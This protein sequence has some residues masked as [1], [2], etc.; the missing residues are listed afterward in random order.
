MA[1]CFRPFYEAVALHLKHRAKEENGKWN[2]NGK[3]LQ[4]RP[5]EEST[6]NI[7]MTTTTILSALDRYER[8]IKK[9]T[10]SPTRTP[11]TP[12]I[13]RDDYE[14]NVNHARVERWLLEP[15]LADLDL[16][17]K[18][19]FINT[20][21][22]STTKEEDDDDDDDDEKT[23]VER[24]M[25]AHGIS[26]ECRFAIES[27]E[28]RRYE[29]EKMDGEGLV[30]IS[31]DS[32]NSTED[33]RLTAAVARVER[34]S[35]SNTIRITDVVAEIT[36]EQTKEFAKVYDPYLREDG[37]L[38]SYVDVAAGKR[39]EVF[40]FDRSD[41]FGT[42]RKS[43]V[44]FF[45]SSIMMNEC[46]ENDDDVNH[47]ED[48]LS[49]SA[50][51]TTIQFTIRKIE[52]T[53]RNCGNE[54]EDGGYGRD[55]RIERAT[56]DSRTNTAVFE[57]LP[58]GMALVGETKMWRKNENTGTSS[59]SSSLS[60][61]STGSAKK[62]EVDNTEFIKKK[63]PFFATSFDEFGERA[64][65][66]AYAS[67]RKTLEEFFSDMQQQQQQQQQK[68]QFRNDGKQQENNNNNNNNNITN[69][70]NDDNDYDVFEDDKAQQQGTIID[71]VAL[72]NEEE[73][74]KEK[75]EENDCDT[76][77]VLKNTQNERKAA[78]V[79]VAKKE[80]IEEEEE[81]NE[82]IELLNEETLM[83][84][85]VSSGK[86]TENYNK[87]IALIAVGK[88]ERENVLRKRLD[89]QTKNL[90]RC[91]LLFSKQQKENETSAESVVIVVAETQ[92]QQQ[93]QQQQRQ[94]DTRQL[95]DLERAVRKSFVSVAATERITDRIL[96][97]ESRLIT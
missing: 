59:I 19:E 37:M 6:Q 87:T 89:A 67:A 93:Q 58:R 85:K 47:N 49:S 18:N 56:F 9:I 96:K 78:V 92:Q 42:F 77:T 12:T 84:L 3:S 83:E 17:E 30:I 24:R 75:E 33:Q 11:T 44:I 68:K 82:E 79:L 54:E 38:M 48:N 91:K 27:E 4:L 70:N 60:A 94:Q 22:F 16:K 2:K 31:G 7:N 36:N 43:R 63:L 50:P 76:A 71:C 95:A 80:E 69:D 64:E 65:R 41:S 35:A 28:E 86:I 25:Y 21:K 81:K 61:K 88:H 5:R 15:I 53:F 73:K 97:R 40:A 14:W 46:D 55:M 90:N 57:F 51:N 1:F 23:N 39:V 66:E 34:F 62:E 32:K 52:E 8:R 20:V 13:T 10:S 26:G 29:R 72:L 45:S 74:E